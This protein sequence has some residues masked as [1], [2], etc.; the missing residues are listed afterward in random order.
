MTKAIGELIFK[1]VVAI[2]E[3]QNDCGEC[4]RLNASV[5]HR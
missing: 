4:P 3:K 5:V 2:C 1:E